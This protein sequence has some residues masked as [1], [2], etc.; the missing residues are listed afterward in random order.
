MNTDKREYVAQSQW[1]FEYFPE[2][3]ICKRVLLDFIAYKELDVIIDSF[4]VRDRLT[5]EVYF[6]IVGKSK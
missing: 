4:C 3:M 1:V 6:S 2:R 5:G